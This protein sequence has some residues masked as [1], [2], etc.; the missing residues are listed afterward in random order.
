MHC[1]NIVTTLQQYC[2]YQW[3]LHL[4]LV[5]RLD[6][7]LVVL[8]PLLLLPLLVRAL[9][10]GGRLQQLQVG[11]VVDQNVVGHQVRR[12]PARQSRLSG[13]VQC[14]LIVTKL[15]QCCY[16]VPEPWRPGPSGALHLFPV[17]LVDLDPVGLEPLLLIH[18]HG[19]Q[20]LEVLYSLLGSKST[21]HSWNLTVILLF[22]Q[23]TPPFLS[24]SAQLAL[25]VHISSLQVRHSFLST[26]GQ[27]KPKKCSNFFFTTSFKS[28]TTFTTTRGCVLAVFLDF[29]LSCERYS[30]LCPELN[31]KWEDSAVARISCAC[32][33]R[34]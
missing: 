23:S 7:V 4:G 21:K 3:M 2:Y 32:L 8:Q 31:R 15:L 34:Q 26:S 13:I 28:S 5:C 27:R 6:P 12:L 33:A 14:L 17:G 11:L 10:G 22:E 1:M 20:K 29:Y 18:G 19:A 16:N 25:F 24:V 30:F 9:E